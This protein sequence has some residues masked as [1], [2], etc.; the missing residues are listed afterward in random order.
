MTA[1]VLENDTDWVLEL[2]EEPAAPCDWE[3][4]ER[5]AKW[6]LRTKC[7]AN[8]V[9]ICTPCR[10]RLRALVSMM[11]NIYCTLCLHEFPDGVWPYTPEEPL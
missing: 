1:T 9:L 5:A 6:I 11:I 10:S 4:C 2:F 8:V 7:C 3:G